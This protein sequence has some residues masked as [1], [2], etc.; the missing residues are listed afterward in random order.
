MVYEE[1][2]PSSGGHGRLEFAIFLAVALHLTFI[3]GLSFESNDRPNIAPQL[4]VTL[5]MAASS[6][7]P[8]QAKLL[9]AADQLGSGD[10]SDRDEITSRETSSNMQTQAQQEASQAVP[11][12]E[13]QQYT[14]PATATAAASE[15]YITRLPEKRSTT[16]KS[17]RGKQSRNRQAC[18]RSCQPRGET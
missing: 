9:A 1:T 10:S 4:E 16:T 15:K 12:L 14:T 13:K 8:E 17:S 6:S 2:Q 18:A 5:T 11:E 3:L 7:A